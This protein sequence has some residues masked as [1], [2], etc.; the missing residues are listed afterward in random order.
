MVEK[1]GTEAG[2]R[3]MRRVVIRDPEGLI[4]SASTD[5][6][7]TAFSCGEHLSAFCDS[8]FSATHYPVVV[9][10]SNDQLICQHG[11]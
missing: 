8:G 4:M 1:C 5:S 11:G 9:A 3:V 7:E 6:V 10:P 2:Y